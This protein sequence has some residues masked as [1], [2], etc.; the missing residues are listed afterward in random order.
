MLLQQFSNMCPGGQPSIQQHAGC[1]LCLLP[2][3]KQGNRCRSTPTHPCHI[4]GF[5]HLF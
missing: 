2:V 4:R 1:I 3:L 5:S